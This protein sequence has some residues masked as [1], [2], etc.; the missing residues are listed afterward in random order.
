[1]HNLYLYLYICICICIYSYIRMYI[2]TS[3]SIPTSISEIFFLYI[4]KN[5]IGDVA[6]AI[7]IRICMIRM[8]GIPYRKY[9]CLVLW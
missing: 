7:T 2:Y 1:M 6:S 4:T 9:Q 5:S 3:I 8:A